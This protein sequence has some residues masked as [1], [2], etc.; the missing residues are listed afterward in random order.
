MRASWESKKERLSYRNTLKYLCEGHH[1]FDCT[2]FFLWHFCCFLC[3]RSLPYQVT[4]LMDGLSKD[5][6]Y[7]YGRYS[8]WMNGGKYENLLQFNTS[9]LASL[10]TWYYN[11]LCFNFS[12]S[13]YDLTLIKKSHTL[14]WQPFLQKFLL[15]T[16]T[17]K[18]AVLVFGKYGSSIYC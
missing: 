18:L 9:W 16:R 8:V 17:Y 2:P 11:R 5:T 10:R 12:C 6:K 1:F 4:H 15:K 7:C 13:G 3:L 14:K